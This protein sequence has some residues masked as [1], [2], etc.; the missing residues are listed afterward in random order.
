MSPHTSS[1]PHTLQLV[2]FD[3]DGTLVDSAADI[4]AAVNGM[5]RELGHPEKPLDTITQW[6]G[7]GSALLVKRSLG[8]ALGL[9]AEDVPLPVF[10]SAHALFFKHYRVTNGQQTRLFTG[11]LETLQTFQQQGIRQAIC[12]NKPAEFTEALL[13]KLG[14]D[15]FFDCVVSGDSLPVK[16]PDAAPL[17]YCAEHCGVAVDRCLMVGDSMTDIKAARHAGMPIICVSYGYHRGDNLAKEC[18]VI[19]DF[20]LLPHTAAALRP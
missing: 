17:L 14:I 2:I 4:A 20:S 11:V 9:A 18:E 19:R 3:L 10:Q 16:K 8:E 15:H 6:V 13:K 5:R 12:T 1:S 7:N